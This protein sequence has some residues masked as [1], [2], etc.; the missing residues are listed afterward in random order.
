MLRY[1]S[2]T[3]MNEMLSPEIQ[4]SSLSYNLDMSFFLLFIIKKNSAFFVVKLDKSQ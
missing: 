1:S 3:R 2:V 4:N